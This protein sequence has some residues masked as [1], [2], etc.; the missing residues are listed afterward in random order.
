MV[1][2]HAPPPD[3]NGAFTG[4][5]QLGRL[6]FLLPLA[7]FSP[8]I[9]FPNGAT[10]ASLQGCE[11]AASIGQLKKMNF[12]RAATIRK[13]MCPAPR[14]LLTNNLR[15]FLATPRLA[16][17]FPMVVGSAISELDPSVV[18]SISSNPFF[19]EL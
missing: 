9:V 15:F 4:S 6:F 3:S 8:D 5:R 1:R 7:K 19:P 14:G 11:V 13:A 12:L 17:G 10:D 2:V 18:R 16:V